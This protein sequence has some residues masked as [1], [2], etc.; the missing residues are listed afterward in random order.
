MRCRCY[1]SRHVG[2]TACL[3]RALHGAG[4]QQYLEERKRVVF[5][6]RPGSV[7]PLVAFVAVNGLLVST[8]SS[9]VADPSVMQARDPSRTRPR[10]AWAQRVSF[11]R[12]PVLRPRGL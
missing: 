9:L 3:R 5:D 7:G 6:V 11:P 4:G 10:H 8:L 1:D 12:P 2:P